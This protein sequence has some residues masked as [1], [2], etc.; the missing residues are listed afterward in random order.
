MPRFTSVTTI[1]IPI[2]TLVV[3]YLIYEIPILRASDTPI[4]PIVAKYVRILL[5]ILS[6]DGKPILCHI[7]S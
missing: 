5:I 6:E 2:E 3:F 7:I 1:E 4:S